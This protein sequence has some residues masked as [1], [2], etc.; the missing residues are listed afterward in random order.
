M[1]A[2]TAKDGVMAADGRVSSEDTFTVAVKLIRLP[3]GGVAGAAGMWGAARRALVWLAN[4]EQGD[5]PTIGD[6]TQVLIMRADGSLWLA[7]AGFP[8]YP[9]DTHMAAIGSGSQGAMVA[10]RM[11]A[12]ALEAVQQVGEVCITVG[13]PYITMSPEPPKRQLKATKKKARR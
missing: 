1:T 13:P 10:M 3:D 6:E 4:G 8:A 9:L 5:P 12:S 7:E 11:G 2:I